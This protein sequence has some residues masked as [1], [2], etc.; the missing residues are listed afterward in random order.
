[1][2]IVP[3]RGEA[4]LFGH[5][6]ECRAGRGMQVK[7]REG[8]PQAAVET[9]VILAASDARLAALIRHAGA[10]RGAVEKH[11]ARNR[12]GL[13]WG[14]EG[15]AD[16]LD[17]REKEHPGS[18]LRGARRLLQQFPTI[19]APGAEKI[20]LFAS[21]APVAAVPSAFLA[22]PVRLWHGDVETSYSANYRRARETLTLMCDAAPASSTR[23][24]PENGAGPEVCR[25]RPSRASRTRS[26]A[27]S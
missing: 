10:A 25:A 20:L 5:R 14:P 17:A 7:R 6:I 2:T 4:V 15:D 21:L 23:T 22:V 27:R 16:P 19:G 1:L 18:G 13:S 24:R 8:V 11:R 26:R 3:Q 9:D 12:A